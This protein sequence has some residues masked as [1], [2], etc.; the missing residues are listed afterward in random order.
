[1]RDD[2][3]LLKKELK[4][5]LLILFSI[6]LLILLIYGFVPVLQSGADSRFTVLASE[7]LLYRGSM[8]ME[9]SFKK[10]LDP[11]RYSF[12]NESGYPYQVVEKAGAVYYAYPPGTSV[13]IAPA[14]WVLNVAG[15]SSHDAAW[16]Y[17]PLGDARVQRVLAPLITSLFVM[18]VYHFASGFLTLP[19]ALSLSL[20]VAF[21]TMAFSTT[22]R[23]LW[24]D[25]VGI[26][27]LQGAIMGAIFEGWSRKN[28]QGI[29]LGTLLA[30]LVF[31]RPTYAT[32]VLAIVVWLWFYRRELVITCVGSGLCWALTFAMFL[33]W[34]T[35][36][37]IPFY[38][39]QGQQVTWQ[40]IPQ[41]LPA[42]LFSPAR[43]LLILVPVLWFI[44]WI[45]VRNRTLWSNPLWH[46]SW[47]GIIAHYVLISCWPLW[48][49]GYCFG[50]R[51]GTGALPFFILGSIVALREWWPERTGTS[52]AVL[53]T[54]SL[55]SIFIHTV[56]ATIDATSD[57]NSRPNEK[58]RH[59]EG[60]D[61][62][63]WRYPQV[64]CYWLN[65]PLPNQYPELAILDGA[66]EASL[67][68]GI[69]ETRFYFARGWSDIEGYFR[70]SNKRTATMIFRNNNCKSLELRFFPFLGNGHIKSQYMQIWINDEIAFEKTIDATWDGYVFLPLPKSK[71]GNYKV[72]FRLPDA[73][74]P[75]QA[76]MGKDFRLLGIRLEMVVLK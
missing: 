19:A 17:D 21:G 1:M 49:G 35:G 54:L 25:T 64:L 8:N 20:V 70:W 44:L 74:S 7:H 11:A 30:W 57:W 66:K 31:V 16:R 43:G 27:L 33:K 69:E 48:W 42:H 28:V 24:S 37:A 52:M 39:A 2:K 76:G 14:V 40:A 68:P 72:E 29:L 5:H 22:S 50:P 38:T 12:P 51:L 73:I 45:S 46:L 61:M 13:L 55:L 59:A 62:W 58:T 53:V 6:G 56:G 26:L 71:D 3:T 41:A 15:L 75:Y 60:E 47:L 18:L 36:S 65:M 10:P 32:A 34:Q 63:D 67:N 4:Q 9:L 23:A